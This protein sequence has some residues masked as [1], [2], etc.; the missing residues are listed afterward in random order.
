MGQTFDR[1]DLQV[2]GY[3]A[4]PQNRSQERPGLKPAARS[5][6]DKLIALRPHGG[7]RNCVPL[8]QVDKACKQ[9]VGRVLRPLVEPARHAH[10][11]AFQDLDVAGPIRS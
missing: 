4:E 1:P 11:I 8:K 9:T 2:G 5:H 10:G 6:S 3:R 7:V